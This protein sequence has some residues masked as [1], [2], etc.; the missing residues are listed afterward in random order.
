MAEKTKTAEIF[1]NRL[2]TATV[3]E[4]QDAAQIIREVLEVLGD[5]RHEG[6]LA[7]FR[8]WE[9]KWKKSGSFT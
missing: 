4:Q 3:K 7:M 2:S 6:N 5:N 8:D 1:L 9:T